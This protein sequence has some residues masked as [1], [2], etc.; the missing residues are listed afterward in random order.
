MNM[1]PD[2]NFLFLGTHPT[3]GTFGYRKTWGWAIRSPDPAEPAIIYV[4]SVRREVN[5]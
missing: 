1:T 3:G 5:H 4:Y 2:D